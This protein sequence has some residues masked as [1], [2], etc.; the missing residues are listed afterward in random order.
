MLLA[1]HHPPILVPGPPWNVSQHGSWLPSQEEKASKKAWNHRLLWSHHI[2]LLLSYSFLLLLY[3]FHQKPVNRKDLT[4][5]EETTQ[6]C[7]HHDIG[8]VGS[9]LKNCFQRKD[10]HCNTNT[11]F[12]VLHG[13]AWLFINHIIVSASVKMVAISAL[14]TTN[15]CH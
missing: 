3:S 9:H 12:W 1:G 4:Q 15:N 7:E 14:S 5:R 11:G 8:H 6:G 2:L 13:K 10:V